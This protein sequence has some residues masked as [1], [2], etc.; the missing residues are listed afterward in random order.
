[1]HVLLRW[2]LDGDMMDLVHLEYT[3]CF[4]YCLILDLLC[5][6]LICF[7]FGW[8]KHEVYISWRESMFLFMM[9]WYDD[10][11]NDILHIHMSES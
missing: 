3:Y 7:P 8:M 9:F 6:F 10:V 1:M 11:V 5:M 4:S 2:R